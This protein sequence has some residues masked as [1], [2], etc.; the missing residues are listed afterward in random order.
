MKIKFLVMH[1]N[2]HIPGFG[3]FGKTLEPGKSKNSSG[4]S[5]ERRDDG[6]YQINCKG[7]SGLIPQAMVKYAELDLGSQSK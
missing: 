5:V 1:D 2:L 7:R 4:V 3:D 6:D